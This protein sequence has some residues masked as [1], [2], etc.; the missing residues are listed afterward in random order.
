MN[1]DTS[2]NVLNAA[3][4]RAQ[5]AAQQIASFPVQDNEVGSPNYKSTDRIKPILSLKE[6][7]LKNSAE[8]K[9]PQT[10]HET[11]GNFVNTVA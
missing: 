3:Q 6:A 2:L 9:L 5:T 1:I 4:Y 7:E 8:V 10:E 11:I